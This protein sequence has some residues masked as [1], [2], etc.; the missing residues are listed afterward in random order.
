MFK[1]LKMVLIAVN[2]LTH[3]AYNHA[4]GGKAASAAPEGAPFPSARLRGSVEGPVEAVGDV[5]GHHGPAQLL[6]RFGV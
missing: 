3:L 2:F 4:C 5:D 1:Y 6:K